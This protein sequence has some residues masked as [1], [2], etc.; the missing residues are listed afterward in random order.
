[1]AEIKNVKAC[2][3]DEQAIARAVTRIAHQ[4]IEK[5]KGIEDLAIIGIQRRGV[6]LA[7]R[8]VECIKSVEGV[9]VPFGILD[10]TLYRDDLSMLSDVPKINGTDI[11]F[12][13]TGKKIVLVD[14]VIFTGRTIR[15]AIDAIMD[16]GRPKLIQLAVLVDRGH[17]ELPFRADYV[18]K[19]V[20]TS[21]D[22]VINVQ[23]KEF[24]G[25]EN[26]LLST[27]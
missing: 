6:P 25:E 9:D 19:N 11:A 4:I 22:E 2:I 18:G 15:A 20:P 21:L 5:N 10:I 8:I 14:D 16:C 17:R 24:D 7:K 26:V 3:M 12:S 23:V 1:M 13:I 27:R